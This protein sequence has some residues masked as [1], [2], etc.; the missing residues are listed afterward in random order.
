MKNIITIAWRNVWRNRLRSGLVITSI[1]L[2]IWAGLFSISFSYGLNA[3]RTRNVIQNV[4]SHI[5]IHHP[6]FLQDRNA[7]YVIPD[8]NRILTYLDTSNSVKAYTSR[9]LINGMASSAR[10]GNGVLITG[11]NPDTERNVTQI[12]DQVISGS[13]FQATFKNQIVLGKRLAEKL[14]VRE[15]SKIVLTFQDNLGNLVT[16]A[17]RVVGI[18]ESNSSKFDEVNVFVKTSDV[19]SLIGTDE[20]LHEIAILMNDDEQVEPF[21]QRLKSNFQQSDIETWREISPELGYA[22]E[23]MGLFLYLF[24]TIIMAALAF[25][26]VNTMLMAVLERKRELGM[27]MAV[28]MNKKRVF[29]MILSET[30]FLAAVG[31][32]IGI[33]LAFGSVEYFGARGIDLSLWGEGLKNF[34]IDTMVY[35]QLS[36]DFYPNIGIMVVVTAILSAIYPARKALQLNPNDA[37]RSI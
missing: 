18:F 15:K 34:G 6:S 9:L 3:Q 28:G 21:A 35:T 27:L 14:N 37:I 30:I 16:G 1:A 8:A 2:G 29:A 5:Q 36:P 7:K 23:V 33:L 17:F 19:H 20:G 10:G 12:H 22:D 24:L 11:V 13:Y 26:I 4:I 31:G 25:G 32:P